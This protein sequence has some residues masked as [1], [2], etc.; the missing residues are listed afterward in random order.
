MHPNNTYINTFPYKL[1]DE[2][3]STCF[4]QKCIEDDKQLIRVINSIGL[5]P[6]TWEDELI[7]YYLF[8]TF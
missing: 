5:L 8:K 1:Q 7:T 3:I 6:G 2:G 4:Y